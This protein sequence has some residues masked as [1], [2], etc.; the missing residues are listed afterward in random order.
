M[1][2]ANKV[3]QKMI[4]AG[5]VDEGALDTFINEIIVPKFVDEQKNVIELNTRVFYTNPLFAGK[6]TDQICHLL[7]KRGFRVEY[8]IV[9]QPCGDS[10][11]EIE[12]PPQGQ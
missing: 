5:A 1:I 8:K 11:Y 7:N 4:A 12:I 9:D 6:T 10:W 3:Y 2:T